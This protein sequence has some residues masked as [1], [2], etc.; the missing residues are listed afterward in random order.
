[1]VGGRFVRCLMVETGK[2]ATVVQLLKTRRLGQG[3]CPRRTRIRRIQGKWRQDRV[4]LLPGYVF[5]FADEEIPVWSY[6]RLEHMVRILRYEREPTGYLQG[7]DLDLAA[8]MCRLDGKLELLDAV[9]ENGF[10]RV[11]DPVLQQL[12][13][14]VLSVDRGKRQA[15]VKISLMGEPRIIQLNYRLVGRDGQ[16]LSQAEEII[17]DM[18]EDESDEWLMAWTPDFAD[19]LTEELDHKG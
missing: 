5:V 9:E 2:E 18:V 14:E 11:T 3:I 17:V 16:P 13:G 12:E 1:M 15:K 19:D 7:H 4:Y 10:I 6:H 8:A